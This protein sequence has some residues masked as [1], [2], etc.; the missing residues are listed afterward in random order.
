MIIKTW[1]R[2]S[3]I[4]CVM[5]KWTVIHA[6]IFAAKRENGNHLKRIQQSLHIFVW[7]GISQLSQVV[8]S[9]TK[10]SLSVEFDIFIV[11]QIIANNS[12]K[13]KDH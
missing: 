5:A 9:Q 3:R 11:I 13:T 1:N 2:C 10:R 4:F 7:S 12:A 6:F 8:H